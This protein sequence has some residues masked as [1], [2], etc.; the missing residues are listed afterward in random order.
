MVLDVCL[1][2]MFDAGC[3]CLYVLFCWCAF[4]ALLWCGLV[5]VVVVRIDVGLFDC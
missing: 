3:L 5:V 1:Y 2:C 4:G